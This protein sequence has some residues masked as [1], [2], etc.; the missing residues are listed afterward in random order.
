M[1]FACGYVLAQ[2]AGPSNTKNE[3]KKSRS[4]IST[5]LE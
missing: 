1:V 2:K 3:G 4:W 5:I